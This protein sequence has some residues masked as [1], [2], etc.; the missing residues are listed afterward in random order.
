M[1]VKEKNNS[2][3]RMNMDKP[4]P[5]VIKNLRIKVLAQILENVC[6]KDVII[7]P[8]RMVLNIV[9]GIIMGIRTRDPRASAGT[10]R[11]V[12]KCVTYV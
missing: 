4:V 12:H 1:K 7:V 5:F 9:I 11:W 10:K 3:K 2:R 6:A 8:K